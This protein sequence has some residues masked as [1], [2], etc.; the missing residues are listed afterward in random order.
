MTRVFV[1]YDP[2]QPLAY[3]V[4]QSSLHRHSKGR[5]Q[6]EPLML[7]KLPITR[8]GLTDFTYSRFLVP[9]L[10]GYEG[11]GIFMDA[12]IVVTGDIAELAAQADGES[13]VQVMQEQPK[14]EWASVMLFNCANCKVL[15]PEYINDPQ[16]KLLELRW[17]K[18]GTF[19]PEWNLCVNKVEPREAKLYHY[20]EGIPHWDEVKCSP[21]DDIWQAE[22]EAATKSV[23]WKELMGGSVH[24]APVIQRYMRQKFG[25]TLRPPG[26]NGTS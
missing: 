21:L 3:N 14:F 6:V 2:R 1:G 25:I 18:V 16:N 4:L 26:S 17:G 11:V 15:T 19:S 9:Y 12:D 8:R 20:T 23:E 13:A 7:H 24:A 10:C 5:V 22:Y